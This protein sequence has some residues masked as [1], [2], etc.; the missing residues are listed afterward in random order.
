MLDRLK[1]LS[2]LI[3]REFSDLIRSD[4]IIM[5]TRIRIHLKDDS[6][7]DIRYPI[8]TDYSFHWQREK[9]TIRIN[10]APDHPEIETFPRHLH[11]GKEVKADNIT[12]IG[13]LPEENLRR[14]MN[15]V[16]KILKEEE[17]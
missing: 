8:N 11:K 1:R 14:F 6:F 10:T 16:R 4:P 7:I 5:E 17:I 9:E 12:E 15:F 13:L 2:D 3:K